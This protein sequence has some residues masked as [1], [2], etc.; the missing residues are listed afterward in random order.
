MGFDRVEKEIAGLFK[1]GVD[2]EVQA[3][4]IRGERVG[5]GGWIVLEFG[6]RGGEVK[7]F[8]FRGFL[9]NLV[10]EAGEEV[11]VVD[12]DGEFDKDVL[13][14]E[15]G[16]LDAMDCVSTSF[17]MRMPARCFLPLRGEFA[18]LIRGGEARA[19]TVGLQTQ[20]PLAALAGI[21]H[22]RDS[23]LIRCLLEESLVVDEVVAHKLTHG[24]ANVPS[25][26]LRIHIHISQQLDHLILVRNVAL[27]SRRGL[28]LV[29]S[30]VLAVVLVVAVGLC[31]RGIRDRSREGEAV[32]DF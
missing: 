4:E 24:T 13:V 8:G 11:G 30:L 10:E 17:C 9:G 15:V 23:L 3:I 21:E 6:E 1:E 28:C 14:S 18:L 2:A 19:Q 29:S 12:L 16:L 5:A 20:A 31:G 32:G 7:G 27:R 22:K 26:N 25:S